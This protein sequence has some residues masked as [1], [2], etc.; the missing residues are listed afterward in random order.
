MSERYLTF[1]AEQVEAAARELSDTYHHGGYIM[2]REL[3]DPVDDGPITPSVYRERRKAASRGAMPKLRADDLRLALYGLGL[4]G[5]AGEVVDHIKKCLFHAKPL[6]RDAVLLEVGDVLWYV[7]K[8]LALLGFSLL[9]ALKANDEKLTERYP[10]GWAAAEKHYDH[11]E[12]A[13]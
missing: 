11:T 5:E 3:G 12:S 7:D 13:S 1:T 2:R 9:D 10:N 6:D 8:L 4:A